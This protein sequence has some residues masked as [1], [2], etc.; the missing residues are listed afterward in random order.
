MSDTDNTYSVDVEV[1]QQTVK[2][3]F[4]HAESK[5]EAIRKAIWRAR[6]TCLEGGAPCYT[7]QRVEKLNG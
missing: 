5:E 3:F 6:E 4:V 7:T 2:T 1:V